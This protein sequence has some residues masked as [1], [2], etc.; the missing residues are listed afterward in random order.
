MT[1]AVIGQRVKSRSAN[2][3][4]QVVLASVIF[5]TEGKLLVNPEG[6]LPS[7]KIAKTYLEEVRAKFFLS[8]AS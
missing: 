3:A 1:F 4:Q 2:Q 6:T 8:G 7:R 5:D